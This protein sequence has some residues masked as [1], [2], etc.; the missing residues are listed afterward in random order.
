MPD[1]IDPDS[2][3]KRDTLVRNERAK[4]TATYVNGLAI[5]VF[6]VGGLSPFITAAGGG[7]FTGWGL[8]CLLVCLPLSGIL[9]LSARTALKGLEP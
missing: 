5:A 3:S 2:Q 8:G 1:D 4:L 9:H 7:G 6:A